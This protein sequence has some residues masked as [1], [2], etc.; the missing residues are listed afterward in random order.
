MFTNFINSRLSMYLFGAMITL[1]VILMLQ[2]NN[3]KKKNSAIRDFKSMVNYETTESKAWQDDA[4]AWRHRS[5]VVRLENQSSMYNAIKTDSKI[6][7][8]VKSVDGIKNNM[9]N[10]KSVTVTGTHTIIEKHIPIHDTIFIKGV[11]TTLGKKF[12]Y[13]DKYTTIKGVIVQDTLYP[14]IENR[15]TIFSAVY[16][17]RKWFLGRKRYTQDLRSSNPDTKIEYSKNISIVKK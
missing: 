8:L 7:E 9:R 5:E 13:Q 2:Y 17:K 12:Y 14:K 3:L 16:W 6:N 1:L 10:L 15:D 11:D 4:G